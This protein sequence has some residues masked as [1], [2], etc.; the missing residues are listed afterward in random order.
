[1]PVHI[2]KAPGAEPEEGCS[3]LHFAWFPS[4]SEDKFG[5][6]CFKL[7]H[8]NFLYYLFFYHGATAP[9]GAGPPHFR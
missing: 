8:N 7:G 4:V 6:Q 2:Q 3:E 5:G 9:S 1:M